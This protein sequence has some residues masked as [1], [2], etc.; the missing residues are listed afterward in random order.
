MLKELI[1]V[2][3]EIAEAIKIKKEKENSNSSGSSEI[4]ENNDIKMPDGYLY[5]DPET[6]DY[7]VAKTLTELFS[8]LENEDIPIGESEQVPSPKIY[9][10]LYKT[11][12]DT[13]YIISG[14]YVQQTCLL[15]TGFE[16]AQEF[17]QSELGYYY[18]YDDLFNLLG[19]PD[20]GGIL[21][22]GGGSNPPVVPNPGDKPR[23]V[24]K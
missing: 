5:T 18:Y 10:A 21:T 19:V 8:L 22:S 3:M 14:Y 17:L 24:I 16:Y 4:V 20:P 13:N 6:G 7:I 12:V 1:K 11:P 23:D 2:L 9:I 15:L